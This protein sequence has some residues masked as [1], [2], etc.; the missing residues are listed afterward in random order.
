MSNEHKSGISGM[1]INLKH[2]KNVRSNDLRI[3]IWTLHILTS[4]QFCISSFSV[5]LLFSVLREKLIRFNQNIL[6][7]Y[8][9]FKYTLFL[10]KK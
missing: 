9:I 3:N 7:I 2:F 4:E 10:D 6:S 8:H 1:P 5:L